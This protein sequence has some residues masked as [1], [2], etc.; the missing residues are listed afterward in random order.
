MTRGL[1]LMLDL[2][3]AQHDQEEIM[4]EG[5]GSHATTA[6]QRTLR[7]LALSF[8]LFGL[9]NNVLY[10]IVLSAA[11]DLVPPST[12]KGLVAFCNIAPAL[13]HVTLYP[14]SIS[15]QFGTPSGC[16]SGLAICTTWTN[17]ILATGHF[18]LPA[19]LSWNDCK[20]L[21]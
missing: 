3:N 20:Q 11:L 13:V 9:I 18:L 17:T 1:G 7:K 16:E 14:L 2:S 21:M 5:G 6:E 4:N 15:N 19:E 12:P 8:F 10:V